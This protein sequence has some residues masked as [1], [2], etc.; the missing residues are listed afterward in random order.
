MKKLNPYYRLKYATNWRSHTQVFIST[1]ISKSFKNYFFI[2]T[3]KFELNI[4]TQ[5]ECD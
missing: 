1:Y 4:F 5:T 3:L 2:E